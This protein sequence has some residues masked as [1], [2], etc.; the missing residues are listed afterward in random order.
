MRPPMINILA[1]NFCCR[2]Q[3][4]GGDG[5]FGAGYPASDTQ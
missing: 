2:N 3:N 4:V 1:R 5:W